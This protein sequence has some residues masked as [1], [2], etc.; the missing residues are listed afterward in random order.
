MGT[1]TVL[2]LGPTP[3]F[4]VLVYAA[5]VGNVHKVRSYSLFN[6]KLPLN[7]TEVSPDL[8]HLLPGKNI[9]GLAYTR[10]VPPGDPRMDWRH[11]IHHQLLPSN[12]PY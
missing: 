9:L 8:F 10:K 3:E 5:P 1:G 4:S 7:T 11:Q 12:I 2:A 6:Q